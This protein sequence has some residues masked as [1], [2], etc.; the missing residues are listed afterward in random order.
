MNLRRHRLLAA[1]AAITLLAPAGGTAS[2][3]PEKERPL[4]DPAVTRTTLENT[5]TAAD[6]RNS[7]P[8]FFA[9]FAAASLVANQAPAAM[10]TLAGFLIRHVDNTGATGAKIGAGTNFKTLDAAMDALEF[11]ARNETFGKDGQGGLRPDVARWILRDP[12]R[13]QN[14][15]DLYSDHDELPE[16]RRILETLYDY[17]PAGRDEFA[18][19]IF[20]MAVVWDQPCPALHHQYKPSPYQPN[21]EKRYDFFKTLYAKNRAKIA[22]HK[23]TPAALVFVVD[24]PVTV[25]E[26]EWARDNCRWSLSNWDA[27]YT[28]IKYDMKRLDA[29]QYDWPYGDY[30]LETIRQKGGIC[31]DQAYFATL[32]A[33]ANGIP[34]M[35]FVGEGRRGPHAWFGYLKGENRWEMDIGRYTFDKFATGV[36][37]NPQTRQP[38]S[39]HEIE[40][41]CDRTFSTPSFQTATLYCKLAALLARNKR[42]D[43][44]F[45]LA[46]EA[47]GLAKVIPAAWIIQEQILAGRGDN[48]AL[49]AFYHEKKMAFK[50][51]S[52]IVADVQQ[53]EAGVLRKQ[54]RD[55]E[56]S[57]VMDQAAKEAKK[58]SRDDITAQLG[59]KEVDEILARNNPLGARLRLEKLLLEKVKKVKNQL[60]VNYQQKNLLIQQLKNHLLLKTVKSQLYQL[61]AKLSQLEIKLVK[62]LCLIHKII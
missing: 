30:F 20:A 25:T 27:A 47:R 54:G 10:Q 7:P 42:E 16:V 2:A 13:V 49:L 44:A 61:L 3:A 29:G 24:T 15:N 41:W 18:S 62:F 50:E 37:L 1:L 5:R 26:L 21:L 48:A 36:T 38:L 12:Q 33:R 39:N 22:F 52:D 45:A 60:K 34:A 51:Y 28:S 40:F 8:F 56:A 55:Q 11:L 17:D 35:I 19:L 46:G 14:W 4:P 23:L 58:D 9:D 43:A 57:Q 32:T 53:N 59:L 31:V 6:L